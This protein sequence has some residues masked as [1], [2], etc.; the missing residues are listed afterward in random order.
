MTNAV[1]P[2]TMLDVGVVKI[3]SAALDATIVEN[4]IVEFAIV[5]LRVQSP[6]ETRIFIALRSQIFRQQQR[7]PQQRRSQLLPQV[8]THSYYPKCYYLFT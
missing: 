4:H 6:K 3:H 5:E 8:R 7:R 2:S 1:A